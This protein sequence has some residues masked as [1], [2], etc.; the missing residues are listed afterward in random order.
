[1][2]TVILLSGKK[3]S[4]K[5]TTADALGYREFT[6]ATRLK[7]VVNA[8]LGDGPTR[9]IG[10]DAYFDVFERTYGQ[11]LQDVGTALRTFDNDCFVKLVIDMIEKCEDDIV[12]VS[13]L[14]YRNELEKML[15]TEHKI[16]SVRLFGRTR[17]DSR[18]NTHHS[19]CDLDNYDGKWDLS[20]N[21]TMFTPEEIADSIKRYVKYGKIRVIK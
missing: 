2:K 10:K 21:T 17:E 4:G 20:I 7:G 14:R 5:S 15:Q 3:G 6:F 9:Y 8:L 16:V 19:E 18:D 11:L 1:M 13:D 12:V